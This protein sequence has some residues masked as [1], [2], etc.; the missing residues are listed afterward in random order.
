MFIKKIDESMVNINIQT[1][2]GR[3]LY[4]FDE[5]L[6][7][8]NY[9]PFKVMNATFGDKFAYLQANIPGICE[10]L[11]SLSDR[12]KEIII[13]RFRDDLTLEK[14]GNHFGINRERV[15]Q[16]IAKALRK[17]RHP[18]RSKLMI[19][20][21]KADYADIE[22]SL[23]YAEASIN[24]LQADEPT[25]HVLELPIESLNLSVRAYNC[26]ARAGFNYV[27]DLSV[28]TM[29]DLMKVRNL[30]RKSLE[31]ILQKLEDIGIVIPNE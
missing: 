3:T 12:E 24:K 4:D 31:E 27:A 17:L 23:G 22:K 8:P 13:L 5:D 29:S 1:E 16:I 14:I 15:R 9:W 21:S 2:D 28:R 10:A 26:L 11:N 7:V 25:R 6:E 30:G 20:V 19:A 18:T